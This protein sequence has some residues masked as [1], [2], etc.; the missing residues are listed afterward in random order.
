MD[1]VVRT[2]LLF[3]GSVLTFGGIAAVIV[4]YVRSAP[5]VTCSTC[6]GSGQRCVSFFDQ[7]YADCD[8][9]GGQGWSRR[10]SDCPP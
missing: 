9:C 6:D 8:E 1:P 3:A 5:R 10:R 2:G 4:Q 7:I